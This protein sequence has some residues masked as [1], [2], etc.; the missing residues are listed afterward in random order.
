MQWCLESRPW[1]FWAL[2]GSGAK[3]F[4]AWSV[5][6]QLIWT[7]FY[8][9]NFVAFGGIL[10]LVNFCWDTLGYV[11]VYKVTLWR[12][13]VCCGFLGVCFYMGGYFLSIFYNYDN[14]IKHWFCS[15]FGHYETFI[16]RNVCMFS[17]L[18]NILAYVWLYWSMNG[19]IGVHCWCCGLFWYALQPARHN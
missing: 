12:I 18:L 14:N 13:W 10:N 6:N 1:F 15:L 19:F 17:L 3:C 7:K 9:T 2:L 16:F 5:L 4:T 8:R 11:G